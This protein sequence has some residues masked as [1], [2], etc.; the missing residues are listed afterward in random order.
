MSFS[1]NIA[2]AVNAIAAL[3][4]AITTPTPGITKSYTYGTNPV[5]FTAGSSLPA[6][7]HINKGPLNPAM[8][9]FGKFE[10][11]YDIDSLLLI[12]ET[13]PDQY[14]GDEG[15]SAKFWI[16]ICDVF[17]SLTNQSSL[18]SS[19]G[20]TGYDMLFNEQPSFAV[21]PWPPTPS[22]PLKWFWSLEYTH[23]FYL[24]G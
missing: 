1:F 23:R 16:S 6:I 2:N 7:V 9:A 5:S 24:E 17:Y 15:E 10:L 22:A 14:P 20:A 19:S 11:Y 18:I 4:D 3:E 13:L 21:R 12:M 8:Q